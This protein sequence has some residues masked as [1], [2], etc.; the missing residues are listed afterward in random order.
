MDF[1]P[2][3]SDWSFNFAIYEL[4]CYHKQVPYI[5]P[6][7]STKWKLNGKIYVNADSARSGISEVLN[8]YQLFLLLLLSCKIIVLLST[9]LMN[10]YV[11]IQGNS[12]YK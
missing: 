8:K 10:V 11:A 7:H 4:V 2:E 6:S 3:R 9:I 12:K 1:E 5:H